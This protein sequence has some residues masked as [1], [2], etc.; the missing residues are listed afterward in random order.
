MFPEKL[1]ERRT[2]LSLSQEELSFRINAELSRQ[3]I[4]KWENGTSYP[5]VDK[6]LILSVI[7]D[8]SL[9]ELFAEELAYLRRE[10]PIDNDLQER[11]PGLFAGMIAFAEALKKQTD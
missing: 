6:L 2:A 7:L 8:I 3:T 10:K 11:F 1:K 9:D 4:S 5:E